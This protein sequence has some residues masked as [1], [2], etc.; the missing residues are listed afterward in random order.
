MPSNSVAEIAKKPLFRVTG[1]DVGTA[2]DNVERVSRMR[3]FHSTLP[4]D[5]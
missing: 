4:L 5:R 2:P 3:Q 1:G